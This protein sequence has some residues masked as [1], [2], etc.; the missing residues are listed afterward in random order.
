MNT[1]LLKIENLAQ[2]FA[3]IATEEAQAFPGKDSP[4]APKDDLSLDSAT[5]LGPGCQYD[6]LVRAIPRFSQGVPTNRARCPVMRGRW[7]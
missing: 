5:W 2:C 4:R 6:L 3:L 7:P 1:Y